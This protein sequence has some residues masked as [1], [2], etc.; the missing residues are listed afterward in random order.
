MQ[1]LAK[2]ITAY[3]AKNEEKY[4]RVSRAIWEYAEPEK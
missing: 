2:K 4:V 3:V 1:E